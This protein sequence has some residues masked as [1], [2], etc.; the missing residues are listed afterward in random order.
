MSYTVWLD[1]G[2]GGLDPGTTWGTRYEKNDNLI[3][4]KELKIQFLEQGFKVISTR[5]DDTFVYLAERTK[6]ERDNKCSIAL[7]CHRNGST[8]ISANGAEIWLH[9]QAP[10]SYV[11]WADNILKDLEALGFKNRKTHKGFVSSPTSDY[12]VN[13]ETNSPSM[14]I[15]LG[16]IGNPKDNNL[17]DSKLPEICACI[18]KR[19]CEFLNVKYKETT[20]QPSKTDYKLRFNPN[21]TVLFIGNKYYMSANSGTLTRTSPCKAIVTATNYKGNHPYHIKSLESEKS[22]VYGWVDITD[23]REIESGSQIV[24]GSTVRL[25]NGATTYT[26]ESFASFVYSREYLVK[27][28]AGDRVVITYNDTIIGAVDVKNLILV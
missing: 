26:G 23:V 20:L 17:F 28:I 5:T 9:S 14:L 13:R 3:Y 15:E 7:S 12:A 24:V 11:T 19:C 2:H 21:D 25:K 4:A 16:F 22:D 1:P 18:V 10:N 8:D 27:S 6:L